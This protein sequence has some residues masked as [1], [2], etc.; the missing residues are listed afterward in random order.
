MTRQDAVS[1]YC[2][3][4]LDEYDLGDVSENL[5]GTTCFGAHAVRE[6]IDGVVAPFGV[7]PGWFYHRW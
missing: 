2:E 7:G 3:A 5:T 1:R 6:V 4:S